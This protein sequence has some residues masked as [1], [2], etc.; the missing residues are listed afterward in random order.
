VTVRELL[1]AV[2][3]RKREEAIWLLQWQTGMGRSDLLLDADRILPAGFLAVWKENWRRRLAGEPLQYIAGSAPFY[4]REFSVNQDVLVPRPET[5]SLVEI[6][7]NLLG[8]TTAASVLDVGTGSGAI[9]LTLQ[10]ERPSWRVVG[11]DISPKALAVARKNGR[12]LKAGVK[13]CRA[14]L[15]PSAWRRRRLDLV[16]SNPP[17]LDFAK[18]KVAR[19]VREWEPRLALEP[20]RAQR[21]AGF[22]ER[23]GWCAERILQ[24]CSSARVSHTALELSPRI[25]FLLERK[26]RRHGR[27]RRV[28]R[29]ADLAGRK[30]FLLVA[31]DHA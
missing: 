14:D 6:C 16:V 31:W 30:R 4:G 3:K 9:A 13:F 5:E 21:L 1:T 7:L 19:D 23:A 26:W 29:Q 22:P 2:P 27:V 11:F 25:A 17:Y 18:D 8:Q 10:L 15:F 20:E 12:K 28:W 24:S